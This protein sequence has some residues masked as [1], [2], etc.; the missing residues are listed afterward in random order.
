MDRNVVRFGLLAVIIL[1]VF[2]AVNLYP[3][4][5]K[6]KPGLD[7]AGGT[8]L[9]YDIDT[10]GLSPA[11][12]DNLAQKL[13][14]ILMK[15]IDP[16]NVQ[17]IIMRPQGDTRIEI[18]VP[19]ASADTHKKR[20]AYDNALEE[21]MEGNINLALIKRSLS[22]DPNERAEIFAQYA[23]ENKERKEILDNLAQT[24]DAKKLAQDKRDDFSKKLAQISES[25]ETAGVNIEMLS[26]LSPS[27]NTMDPN[28]KEATVD[29]LVSDAKDAKKAREQIAQF[30]EIHKQW[31]EVVNELTRPE[32]GLNAIYRNAEIRL[33]DFNL[34]VETLT[35]VL[36]MPEKS[37]KRAEMIAQFKEGFPSRAEKIDAMVAAFKDY[38]SVR[39]RIDGPDDVKRMLKGAG[40]LE[41]RI[42][43]KFDDGRTNKD[44]LLS[45][46]DALKN[47]GPKQAS[48]SKYVWI[49]IE[50]VK[51]PAWQSPEIV[52]GAF[53]DKYYVLASNQKNESMLRTTGTKPWKLTKSRP[54][55][56]QLGKRAI[57]FSFDEVGGSIFYNITRNNLQRPLCIILDDIAL[58]APNIRSEIRGNGIIEGSFTQIEQMDMVDKL[59][60]GSLPA[61]LIEPPISEKTI[62]PSIGADNRDKGI[63]AAMIGLIAVAIFMV[64]YY[65][66]AGSIADS[67]LFMNILF[68]LAI[69]ALSKATFTLPGIA[70]IILTIGMSVD[71]N[72]L[73]FE[74]IRE[75]QQKG[76]SLRVAIDNGYHRAFS[77]IFDSN[78]TTLITA[79][80]LYMVASEEIKG[81]AITLML[82]LASSM[83]TALFFTR[84]V[85]QMLLSKGIIKNHLTMLSVVK[86]PSINW[87]GLRPVL[88]TISA[89]LV[90]GGLVAFFTRD[91]SKNSKYDIE[92]TGGTSV[93]ID[94]KPDNSLDR[95]EVEKI[96]R[97]QGEKLG[98]PAIAA[99]KVYSVG[100][101]ESKL[102][103]E[104]TTTATNKAI[105]DITF[106]DGSA[107]TAKSVKDAIEAAQKN[108][109]GRLTNL[110]VN[111]APDNPAKFTITTSQTN[112]STIND[113]LNATFGDKTEISEPRISE[114]VTSAVLDAFEGK[115]Q[116]LENLNPKITSTQRIDGAMID[117]APELSDYLDGIK[118]NFT[119]ETPVTLAEM[120]R[121]FRDLQF[122][123]DMRDIE[124]Y[125]YHVL[126]PDYT[127]T[128]NNTPLTE[129]VYVSVPEDAGFRQLTEDEWSSYIS[130]E[131]NKIISAAEME[132]SLSRVIQFA[133]SIGNEA[134]TRAL[135]AIVL[136]LIAMIAYLWV[137]FG[138]LRYGLGA[139][140]ALA[141]DVCIALGAIAISAYIAN[142][143]LG[144]TLLISDFK[145]DLAIVAALLTLVGYS[146]N[147]TIVVFDRIRENRGKLV[148]LTDQIINNSINQ[149]LSRTILTSFTT[150]LVVI[151][152]YIAGGS[153]F[154]G[155][156]YIMT[157][158]IVV[159]TYSSIAIAAPLLILG[160]KKA[161]DA[162]KKQ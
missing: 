162:S 78:I 52:T 13:I 85:F 43:P 22:K 76:A 27:W 5:E 20:Q 116:L 80:I 26:S 65:T 3:P 57:E 146:V 28:E 159:G 98:N 79:L 7:L 147:D 68:V 59:N 138:N 106:T 97:Q 99:A 14:P 107:Q 81:F 139:V 100:G 32:T 58:S 11:E 92:F 89:I 130:N 102:Q 153:G 152:M 16:A 127:V 73:I 74:R 47:R 122:K 140:I 9:I 66:F 10:A 46:V 151:I 156:N 142:T 124:W 111:S 21:L 71:A 112:K 42:L 41:F 154:R 8:S 69:M 148:T 49:E 4:S 105:V 123:P 35:A 6:L 67:A 61:R 19:L 96:I 141:H 109:R 160:K 118:I 90:I 134:K 51:D 101:R 132:T 62:G 121:R 56:D 72:V 38:R 110:D 158:G 45:Y 23:A 82:G 104:I 136:S 93:Q 126:K 18:Q 1:V 91:E 144:Q 120:N 25:L 125:Q 86:S 39:G 29:R 88:F 70:G 83:F 15:R 113:I 145:I 33:R 2:A 60:A 75:E 40:V 53:G 149:T 37:T 34:N 63:K 87:M 114:T 161:K 119:V 64:F 103:Y 44:E 115:L 12:T 30:I 54:S 135:I 137:R 157:I 108:V 143:S 48:D 36:E 77:T 150:F 117:N 128:D 31:A 50:N 84:I 55:I 94:L 155:F 133:P 95:S 17:N 129:F 131:T 24:Y